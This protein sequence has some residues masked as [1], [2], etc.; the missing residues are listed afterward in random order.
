MVFA[1]S[2]RP[3]PTGPARSTKIAVA[4][5]FGTGKTTFVGA[6]SEIVPVRTEALVTE[7]SAGIDSL[8]GL[9]G[10]ESTTVAMD[11]GRITMSDELTLYLFGTPGQ[12]RF[13]FM[14]DDIIRGA[15]GA[16]VLVDLRRIDESFAA[17]DYF[18]MREL[19]FIIAENVF[20]DSPEVDIG[21]IREALTVSNQ[22]PILRIDA[23]DRESVKRALITLTQ[24][25]LNRLA[26]DPM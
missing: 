11:F 10:K 2:D 25:A 20:P 8:A 21:D 22:V 6:I 18:E 26:T 1:H 19:P 16:V 14:W 12:H 24:H 3:R 9:P 17:I 5:G 4:G 13:W 7:A 15:I 23:R